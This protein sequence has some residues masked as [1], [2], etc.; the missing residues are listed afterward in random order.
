[1]MKRSQARARLAEKYWDM[2][3]VAAKI[4]LEVPRQRQW[5]P[6]A[7]A[8]GTMA[9]VQRSSGANAACGALRKARRGHAR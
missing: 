6:A 4:T 9:P 5:A 2:R 8:R 7:E 1:M 3:Q